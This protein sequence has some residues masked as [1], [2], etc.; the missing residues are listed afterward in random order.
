M[1]YS[2][3]QIS[4]IVKYAKLFFKISEIAILIDVDADVLR[5][6]IGNKF[7]PIHRVYHRAKL[8]QICTLRSQEIEQAELGSNVAIELVNKYIQEQQLDE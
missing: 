4:D 2:E 6:D 3:L 8:E 7:H 5:D 1:N